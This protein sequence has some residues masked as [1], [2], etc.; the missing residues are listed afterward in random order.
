MLSL[1]ICTGSIWPEW[2]IPQESLSSK[3]AILYLSLSHIQFNILGSTPLISACPM[4]AVD[5]AVNQRT[6]FQVFVKGHWWLLSGYKGID[7]SKNWTL[8]DRQ[9]LSFEVTI[10][11]CP[12]QSKS[13]TLVLYVLGSW[14]KHFKKIIQ[15]Y[16]QWKLIS[17]TRVYADL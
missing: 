1:W 16:I 15:L 5:T 4:N 6:T 9:I 12:S 13:N 11:F 14:S 10:A 17:N 8:K 3:G 2:E 7:T